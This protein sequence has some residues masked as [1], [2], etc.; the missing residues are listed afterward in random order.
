[1]NN[2]HNNSN[3][4]VNDMCQFIVKLT[5]CI[6]CTLVIMHLAACQGNVDAQHKVEPIKIDDVYVKNIHKVV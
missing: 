3:K 6:Y 4:D 5:S 2:Q 1:M